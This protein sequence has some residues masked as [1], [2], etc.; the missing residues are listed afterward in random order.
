M[1]DRTWESLGS[2]ASRRARKLPTPGRWVLRP[3][4]HPAGRGLRAYSPTNGHLWREEVID[5]LADAGVATF[6]LAADSV[7]DRPELEKALN[8]MRRESE[9]LMAKRYL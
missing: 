7:G 8:P 4:A 2:K 6:N 1:E 5:S 9:Y 3:G